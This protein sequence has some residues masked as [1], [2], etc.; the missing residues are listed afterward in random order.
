VALIF[1]HA[2]GY[3]D[4]QK[5]NQEVA[6]PA[7]RISMRKIVDLEVAQEIAGHEAIKTTKLYDRREQLVQQAEIERVQF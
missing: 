5:P 3:A 2:Q 6:M 1:T 4:L 7:E